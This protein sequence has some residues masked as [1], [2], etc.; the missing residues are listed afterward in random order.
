MN[1]AQRGQQAAREVAEFNGK[2]AIGT[3]VKYWRGA[4]EGEGKFGRTRAPAEVL[5]GHTA[6]VW[7]AGCSGSVALSHVEVSEWR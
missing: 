4:R 1:Q 3:P 6:V 7:I 5:G 2:H